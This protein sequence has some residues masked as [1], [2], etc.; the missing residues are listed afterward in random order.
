MGSSR[1]RDVRL[2]SKKA[3]DQAVESE[4]EG[5]AEAGGSECLLGGTEDRLGEWLHEAE[6]ERG[7]D[8]QHLV[9]QSFRWRH[10]RLTQCLKNI[11]AHERQVRWPPV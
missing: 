5:A 1:S 8:P 11:G 10:R 2:L 7:V 4:R 6:G 3:A 9:T